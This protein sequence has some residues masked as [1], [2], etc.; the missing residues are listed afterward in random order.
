MGVSLC[1][2]CELNFPWPEG[3]LEVGCLLSLSSAYV[4]HCSLD[5]VSAW[6]G[7]GHSWCPIS[8]PSMASAVRTHLWRLRWKQWLAP[9]LGIHVAGALLPESIHSW[10]KKLLRQSHHPPHGPPNNGASP[11]WG[12]GFFPYSLGCGETHPCPLRLSPGN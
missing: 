1:S 5:R 7:G 10:R 11:H 12:P 2:L 8:G 9:A 6:G 3:R 4:G